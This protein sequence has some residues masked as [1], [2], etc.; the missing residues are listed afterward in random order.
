[1]QQ[2][3]Q[4]LTHLACCRVEVKGEVTCLTVEGS[5]K[6]LLWA[7][8]AGAQDAAPAGNSSYHRPRV[9]ALSEKGSAVDGTRVGD[10]T[11]EG[12]LPTDLKLQMVKR[13]LAMGIPITKHARS[14]RPH[15]TVLCPT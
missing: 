1:M 7:L 13:L 12:G 3:Q 6:H 15:D 2:L 9:H 10:A 4:R 11:T 5:G 14:G 8:R